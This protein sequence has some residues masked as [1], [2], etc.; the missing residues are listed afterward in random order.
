[1]ALIV[2]QIIRQTLDPGILCFVLR[3]IASWTKIQFVH[4]CSNKA[5]FSEKTDVPHLPSQSI[6][7]ISVMELWPWKLGQGHQNQISYWSCPI[8]VGLQIR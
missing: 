8:Y 2:I 6:M 5:V 4:Q 3:S 1:M 7:A